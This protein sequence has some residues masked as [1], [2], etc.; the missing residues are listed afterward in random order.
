MLLMKMIKPMSRFAGDH[1]SNS[2][3]SHLRHLLQRVLGCASRLGLAATLA[4][5]L[6]VNGWAAGGS[7]ELKEESTEYLDDEQLPARSKPL[8]EI[9]EKFLSTGN[10]RR[11]IELPTG[12]VWTPAFWVYGNFRSAY[13]KFDVPGGETMSEWANRLDLFAN[14]QLTGTE[15]VLLG[16]T[17]LHEN[18]RFSGRIFS[19]DSSEE[20]IEEYNLRVDTFFFE[21]DFAELFP[22]LDYEDSSSN[23]YG[24]S[25]G[26][27]LIQFQD[28]FLVND[29]MDGFGVSKNNIRFPGNDAIINIRS[30]LFLGLDKVHRH[31]NILDEDAKL[32]GLFNQIDG[33]NRT[34]NIDFVYVD[35][36][37]RGDL[38]NFGID[39][40]QRLGKINQTLRLAASQAGGTVTE[41]ADDGMI[42]F[43]E[44]SV[45]PPRTDDNAYFNVFSTFDNYRSAARGPAAGGPLGRTGILFSGQSLGNFPTP[46]SNS[47]DESSGFALGYQRFLSNNRKQFIVETG[48]RFDQDDG[49]ADEYGLGL[50]YQQALGNRSFLQFDV[51]ATKFDDSSDTDYGSRLE[52][53]VKF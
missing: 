9:G 35:S 16:L 18:G 12:A 25:I 10:I 30:S 42:L 43:A 6:A 14:L 17:P 5:G 29:N 27:Q 40:T 52:L 15:R 3:A 48:G 46:I 33:L 23:D 38:Y 8:V 50:R 45:V 51:F 28:G 47:A 11:G 13:Q 31:T 39:A 37:G 34:Y 26:R 2:V 4:L 49:A 19:P 7:T 21:G 20:R 24:F 22:R 1:R 44:F 32:F 53:Q 41:D 36:N